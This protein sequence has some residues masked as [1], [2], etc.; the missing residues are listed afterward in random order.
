LG[1]TQRIYKAVGLYIFFR[2]YRFSMAEAFKVDVNS[3]IA[4]L[5]DCEF[6]LNVYFIKAFFLNGD[7]NVML[8][9][10]STWLWGRKPLHNLPPRST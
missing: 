10:L 7:L 4:R 5:L 6:M 8:S 9:Q 2:F 3:I 1:F